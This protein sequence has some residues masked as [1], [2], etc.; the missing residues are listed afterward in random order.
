MLRLIEL[1]LIKHPI[2]GDIKLDMSDNTDSFHS[3]YTTIIIGPNGTG[4]SNLLQTLV[5]IFRETAAILRNDQQRRLVRGYYYLKYSFKGKIVEIA[6]FN[7]T[8][9]AIDKTENNSPINF[10]VNKEISKDIT[11]LPIKILASSMIFTDK[12]PAVNDNNIPQYKYLGVRNVNSPSSAGT[13]ITNTKVVDAL[14]SNL[15]KKDFLNVLIKVLNDLDY[16]PSIKVSYVPKY[17]GIFYRR[18]LD[19]DQFKKM[20]VNWEDTFKDRSSAPWGRDHLPSIKD[21]ETLL[22]NIVDFLNNKQFKPYG[23]GGRFFEYDLLDSKINALDYEILSHLHKLDLVSFPRIEL[24]KKDVRF[25]ISD[26]SSGEQN[27]LFTIF[28]LL[29]NVENDSVILID[30]PELSLHPNWQMQYL[31]IVREVFDRYSGLHFLIATHSHFLISDIKG[32]KSK[33][34]G[35]KKENNQ[36]K[37]VDLPKN[38]DTYGWSAEEILYII[39]NVKTTRNYY[40]EADL[41]ELLHKISTQSNDFDRMENIVRDLRKLKLSVNDPLNLI[42]DKAE[43][44][45]FK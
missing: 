12:F 15:Y 9:E 38:I 8:D 2:I 23:K 36:I 22:E 14:T 35:L 19:V 5:N 29:A 7:F 24:E 27:I 41:R 30:E 1:K 28:T 4:K 20:F 34:I 11:L 13:R 18:D 10:F 21:N 33:I 39:F 44:Y 17:R 45:L 42:I 43:E 26:S 40:L 6:N 37:V 16:A 3:S 32:D 31:S 25:G